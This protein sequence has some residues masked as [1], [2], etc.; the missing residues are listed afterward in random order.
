MPFL[1][2]G[3]QVQTLSVG[4]TNQ[5]I[6][7]KTAEGVSVVTETLIKGKMTDNIKAL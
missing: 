7:V 4:K 1:K 6:I 2:I 3:K 5:L